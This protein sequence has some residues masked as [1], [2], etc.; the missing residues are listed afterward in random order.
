MQRHS[1]LLFLLLLQIAGF[2]FAAPLAPADIPD[3]L[4]PWSR[5]VLWSD[6]TH[7]CPLLA[8]TPNKR[9]CDWPASL[10]LTLDARGGPFAL[11]VE[12]FAD[13]AVTLPGDEGHWPQA[14]TV[15]GKPLA[16][17][18][19]AGRP[20]AHLQPGFH[21]IAGRFIW[22]RLPA[23]L[24]M[25]A[26]L[27]LIELNVDRKPVTFPA[28]NEQD[29]LWLAS[30][31]E[32]TPI[33]SKS[34]TLKLKV[35]R[36]IQDGVPMQVITQVE[37]DVSGRDREVLLQ[38]ILPQEAIPMALESTLPA[39]LGTD[40][41]LHI[42]VQPGH[43]TISLTSRFPGEITELSLPHHTA[44]WP[45][46]EI[47]TF[48]ANPAIRLAEI[49]GVAAI[50]PRQTELPEAWQP[51]PAYRLNQGDSLKF[52]VIRRGDPEPDPDR[53]TLHRQLW[54]DF[55][56]G[57]FTVNDRIG[58]QMTRGW[59]LDS[60][61]GMVLGRVSINEQ[62]QSITLD[63]TMGRTGVEVRRGQL[64]LSSDS[65]LVRRSPFSATGWQK[66][67]QSV[68]AELNLP[69]GW[70][71]FAALGVDQAAGA[72]LDQ[73][74][75]LDFFVVLTL[76]LSVGRL[77]DWRAGA[78]ALFTLTLIWQEPGAPRFVWLNLLAASALLRVL[79]ANPATGQRAV[80]WVK[81]YRLLAWVALGLIAIPFVSQQL[82]GGLY[83]Q[84]HQPS[85][86]Y[87]SGIDD[88]SGPAEQ[89]IEQAVDAGN[90]E[91]AQL[92]APAPP[93]EPA[94]GLKRKRAHFPKSMSASARAIDEADPN[95]IT[96]TGPGLPDWE[97]QRL[98]LTW[99]G[100]VQSTQEM[101][102]IL[103]P[104]SINLI[105]NLLRVLLL[106]MLAGWVIG[107][108]S[109]QWPRIHGL[110]GGSALSLILLT[111]VAPKIGA[112]E[113]PTQELLNELK[114]RL[115]AP[116]DCQ[117]QCVDIPAL[118]L[119][120]SRDSLRITLDIH[121]LVKSGIALPAQ[122]GQWWPSRVEVDGK[123]AQALLRSEEGQL[124]VAVD[125]GP[126]SVVMTGALPARKKL[127]IPLTFKPHRVD[128]TGTDWRIEGIGE[129]GQPDQQLRLMRNINDAENHPKL[130]T[131]DLPLPGFVLVER[132]LSLHLDWRVTTLVRRLT[133]TEHPLTLEIPLLNGESILTG[134]L[135]V[136][137][138][139]VAISLSPGQAEARWE[140]T[141]SQQSV[142]KLSAPATDQWTE[143][144]RLDVNP[145]WHIQP[146]GIA[147][148]HHQTA[149]GLWQPEWRP[150]PEESITLTITRPRGAAG[151]T[152][153]LE[154]S[155]LTQRPGERATSFSLALKLRSSQGGQQ[156]ITLPPGIQLQTVTID[157]I[158]Q[159]IRQ[160]GSSMMLPVHP[161]TQT[162]TVD[163]ISEEGI[164]NLLRT[165][166]IKLGN[167]S[168]N[169]TTHIELGNNRWVLLLGG[170]VLGPAV[171]FWGLLATLLLL[172]YGLS[173]IPDS[174]A[175]FRQWA[176]LLVGLSQASLMGG[177]I[178]VG[179]LLLLAWRGKNGQ[180]LS[181]RGFKTLQ[182]GL[183]FLTLAALAILAQAVAG[184]LL[185]LP[186][187]Q[188][189]GFGSDAGHLNWY[190]DRTSD[191]LP[192]PW[193]VSVPLWVYRALM[194]G[195][196]LWLANTLLN[197][198]R[199]GWG[200]F[201]MAGLWTRSA[202]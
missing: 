163:W 44:P 194:L 167:P 96:Q 92:P 117:P 17:M 112:S 60:G 116:A 187:M 142:L 53:L 47:W 66:D 16:V 9:Q 13:H 51:L 132:T 8:G 32:S 75:L 150:W 202:A 140:S 176:L 58:G 67:F 162:A 86:F 12:T 151:S 70:R 5:W 137:D 94:S 164:I 182:V 39:R 31:P 148:V 174:P 87:A 201:I 6:K 149:G 193:V 49:G 28:L 109:W 4:K 111:L 156:K 99:K 108:G 184:G 129:N 1:P 188:I 26:D 136:H 107:G 101:T 133:P 122:F 190:Q 57:G 121:A 113:F 102:L 141:L 83:P 139:K 152:L 2:T 63:E 80:Q 95:A 168:V 144:W 78:L 62:P 169:A 170:T 3:P 23:V 158:Q 196:A 65:R 130:E 97:W 135:T 22:D 124:W 34:D 186:A 120:T 25:P 40:G 38:G 93:S 55:D 185:G 171:L 54:L 35:F 73:W 195:W 69:P 192:R 43:W 146:E 173:R 7:P 29:Q 56:G 46:E 178:V 154:S 48:E 30:E 172:A 197:W 166:E 177:G 110:R 125:A 77:W 128:F 82:Q 183:A 118:E 90:A 10:Q 181:E 198:L 14:V 153:T 103:I 127:E 160:E 119:K 36:R 37:F 41:V 59:R 20:T 180:N 131:Q 89:E 155:E 179:W 104:P 145:T 91:R 126:H 68:S 143:L 21:N 42:Q 74:T 105:L 81:A 147:V 64:N 165:P 115:I 45:D 106:L 33:A 19:A 200:C 71:L 189:A 76:T 52:N 199:W 100:P 11:S 98:P 123:P 24:S 161:G 72:W 157:G 84:L 61:E 175:S 85:R 79:P 138:G 18:N 50:D 134:D 159:P 191:A 15:D 27:A 114:A 88:A